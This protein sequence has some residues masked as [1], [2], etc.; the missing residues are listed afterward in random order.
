M[1]DLLSLVP[2]DP[3]A[4]LA[5]E[6]F[7]YRVRKYIGAYM[8]A[9]G[10]ADGLVFG[11]GIGEN[12]PLIRAR[13]CEPLTWSGLQLDPALNAAITGK[14]GVISSPTSKV[15]AYVVP[16][17]EALLIAQHIVERLASPA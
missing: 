17:D 13:I 10:G 14:A 7:C 5:V 2:T 1:R 11:G 16:V 8:A 9:L 4:T 3:R 6:V 15:L 12:A